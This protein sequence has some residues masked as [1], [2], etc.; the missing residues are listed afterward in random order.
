MDENIR[1]LAS[2]QEAPAAETSAETPVPQSA[3]ETAEPTVTDIVDNA[4]KD[5]STMNGTVGIPTLGQPNQTVEAP[6]GSG[7][8]WWIILLVVALLAAAGAV[9]FLRLK[10]Q[11]KISP[12]QETQPDLPRTKPM[13]EE[14]EEP[15]PPVTSMSLYE[16]GYAQTIGA[17]ENQEDAFGFVYP[18]PLP[19]QSEKLL[20]VVCDGMGGLDDG[21]IASNTAVKVLTSGFEEELRAGTPQSCL[22][23]LCAKA[24]TAVQGHNRKT[25]S[26]T[27]C[28][29]VSI[30]IKDGRLS[31]LSVGDSR[32]SLYRNRAL[33]QL[34][35]EHVLGQEMDEKQAFQG[36][37]LS[38]P[39]RRRAI[40]SH[41]GKETFSKVDRNVNPFQLL[42]GDKILLMS[43]GLFG[44]LSEDEILRELSLPAQQAA[45]RLVQA[46]TAKGMPGQDNATVVIVSYP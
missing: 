42:H 33:L 21:Q 40:T 44:A 3:E 2:A 10:K 20:A 14:D 18:K 26:N 15:V 32:I 17:R 46:V 35:R 19:G 7:G 25:G 1:L 8:L 37:G 22:L 31:F 13:E 12:L 16:I 43:D 27:G 30:L 24:Q 41:I 29:L 4:Q 23:N 38:D 9:V 36:T 45:N 5:V 28:T 6:K 34:N 39:V 11:P